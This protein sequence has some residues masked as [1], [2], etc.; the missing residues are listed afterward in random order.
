MAMVK[1]THQLL[2]GA[3]MHFQDLFT[4]TPCVFQE[5]LFEDYPAHD[6][7]EMN[8]AIETLPTATEVLDSIKSLSPDSAPSPDGFTGQFFRGCWEII[9]EDI[10]AMV[11]GFLL[12]DHLHRAIKSTLLIL[13]PKVDI[14]GSFSD[15]RPISLSSFASKLVDH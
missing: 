4:A 10:M 12:G 5:E 7:N 3:V 11:P 2:T 15:F 13:I 9:Q 14:P 8:I 6:T 1:E